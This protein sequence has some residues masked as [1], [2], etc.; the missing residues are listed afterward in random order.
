MISGEVHVKMPVLY[1]IMG[2]FAVAVI[3]ALWRKE[4]KNADERNPYID[5][6]IHS[7]KVSISG[8]ELPEEMW[9]YI[10]IL[11]ETKTKY[12]KPGLYERVAKR[13]FDIVFSFIINK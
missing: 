12:R 7:G 5:K 1:I 6:T 8:D 3:L 13:I 4:P 9:D 2:I 10:T 11:R